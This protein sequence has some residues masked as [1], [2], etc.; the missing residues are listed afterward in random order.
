MSAPPVRDAWERRGKM[1]PSEM[2]ATPIVTR[3]QAWRPAHRP[4]PDSSRLTPSAHDHTRIVAQLPIELSVSDVER[5]DPGR[6][7][8]LGAEHR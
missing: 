5:D 3:I 4:A 8:R 2:K 7:V 6:A 1:C